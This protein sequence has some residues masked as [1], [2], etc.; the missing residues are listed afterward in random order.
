MKHQFISLR[1]S[2]LA[3]QSK[4]EKLAINPKLFDNMYRKDCTTIHFSQL[5]V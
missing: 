4:Q 5:V 2:I 1:Y 3:D